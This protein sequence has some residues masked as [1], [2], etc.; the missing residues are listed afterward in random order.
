MLGYRAERYLS[1]GAAKV[2]GLRS[3]SVVVLR[4]RISSN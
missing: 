3:L 2:F 1:P 4:L